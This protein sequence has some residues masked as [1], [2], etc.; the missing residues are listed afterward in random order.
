MAEKYYSWSPYAY[1]MNNPMIYTDPRGD[2]VRVYTETEG[3]GHAWMTIGEGENMIL[4]SFGPGSRDERKV[5]GRTNILGPG[6]LDI[7]TG[8]KALK[9][10]RLISFQM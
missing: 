6:S 2:S 4:Y 10:S 5:S 1:V 3:Y 9:M 8:K 7:M